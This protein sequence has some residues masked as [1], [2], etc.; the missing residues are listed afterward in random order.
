MVLIIKTLP[1]IV[2]YCVLNLE[3]RES[4]EMANESNEATIYL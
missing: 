4:V 3:I 2:A 1:Y